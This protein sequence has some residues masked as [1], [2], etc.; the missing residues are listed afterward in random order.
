MKQQTN[1]RCSKELKYEKSNHME[2]RSRF[3]TS[4]DVVPVRV[5]R[6]ELLEPCSLHDVNPL[7]EFHLN[8][9]NN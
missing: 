1:K 5:I 8:K 7:R 6:R 4:P 9:K 2:K 3:L